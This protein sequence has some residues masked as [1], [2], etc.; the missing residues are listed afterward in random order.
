MKRL[1][2][3]FATAA[4][5]ALTTLSQAQTRTLGFYVGTDG[6]WFNPA[7]WSTGSVPD[8]NTDVVI[9]GPS[10]VV[11]DPA[12]GSA[13]VNIHDLLIVCDATLETKAGTT[14]LSRNELIVGGELIH[15]STQAGSGAEAGDLLIAW[16]SAKL[17]PTPKSKRIIVLQGVALS[18]GLGG[19]IPASPTAMGPGT[20]AT[21]TGEQVQVN[22]KLKVELYYGFTP[23]AGQTFTIIRSA[24]PILGSYDGLRE[25][26]LVA[27]FGDVGLYLGYGRDAAGRIREH[28]LLARQIRS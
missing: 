21:L 19:T 24:T 5:A 25:G 27:R 3:I 10:H 23:R 1:T 15:R 26:S 4:L 20:Y 28:I 2:T 11:I 18:M 9:A 12:M 16:S 13:L 6:N 17:N 14:F 22:G 7:N 8:A